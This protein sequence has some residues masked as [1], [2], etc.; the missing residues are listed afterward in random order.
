M[1]INC[2]NLLELNNFNNFNN[3]ERSLDTDATLSCISKICFLP[4]IIQ[5]KE[6]NGFLVNIKSQPIKIA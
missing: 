6:T 1:T 3:F 5:K 4:K 2:N